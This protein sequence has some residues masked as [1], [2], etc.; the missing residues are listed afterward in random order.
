MYNLAVFQRVNFNFQSHTR[1][2]YRKILTREERSK[3]RILAAYGIPGSDISRMLERSL[4]VVYNILSGNSGS[5]DEGD[6]Y[7]FVSEEFAT[8]YAPLMTGTKAR[9][10]PSASTSRSTTGSVEDSKEHIV[11]RDGTEKKLLLATIAVTMTG[12]TS[13]SAPADAS[14]VS[15]SRIPRKGP[16][17]RQSLSSGVRDNSR[18]RRYMHSFPYQQKQTRPYALRAA[19]SS[20]HLLVP[21]LDLES[22]PEPE[23]DEIRSPL[24]D[25]PQFLA[26]LEHD[27]SGI[28]DALTEQ[29]L[30]T[31]AKLFALASWPED[32][33]HSLF[34]EALPQLT[35]AQRFILVKGM[36]KSV[37][38]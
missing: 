22:S 30:G 4:S 12:T 19:G 24:P 1:E 8:Q 13:A 2:L 25:L 3:I 10:V 5:S 26:N 23:V 15:T 17:T 7:D 32:E 35:V 18:S 33:L 21:K 9:S 34:K 16:Y 29:D 31:H 36:R 28:M 14:S 11:Q 20:R 27:I 38:V 6:D 37:E